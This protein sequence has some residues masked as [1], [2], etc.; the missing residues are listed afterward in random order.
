MIKTIIFLIL[1]IALLLRGLHVH[2]DIVNIDIK[3]I[4]EMIPGGVVIAKMVGETIKFI[5]GGK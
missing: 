3:S 1:L 5:T 2:T 4:K